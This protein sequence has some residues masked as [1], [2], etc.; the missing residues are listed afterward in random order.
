[1]NRALALASMGT[2]LWL[3]SPA[4]AQTEA[5]DDDQAPLEPAEEEHSLADEGAQQRARIHFQAGA[6]Y[7]EAGAY[8]DALREWSRAYDLSHRA[9]LLYNFSLAHQGLNH[10]EQARDYLRQFL[11][12][13]TD[14]PNRANLELRIENLERRI[15]EQQAAAEP[16]EPEETEPSDPIETSPPPPQRI[17]VEGYVSP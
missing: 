16:V 10:L 13:V 9:E 8:E 12:Q 14:I 7:Y 11:D 5:D 6:S 3:A 2:W 17:P 15:A 4:V 1:M